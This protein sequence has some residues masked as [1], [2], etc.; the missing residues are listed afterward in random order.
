ML[1]KVLTGKTRAVKLEKVAVNQEIAML[2]LL[3]AMKLLPLLPL[4]QLA[5]PA[6]LRMTHLMTT[7]R[8]NFPL[9][10]EKPP[11]LGARLWISLQEVITSQTKMMHV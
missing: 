3:Q 4:L 7:S 11:A 1:C 2:T 6:L 10:A 5:Q 8:F 9:G